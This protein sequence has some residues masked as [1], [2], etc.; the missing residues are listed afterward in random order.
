MQ[1]VA[2][3]QASVAASVG[4]YPGWNGQPQYKCGYSGSVWPDRTEIEPQK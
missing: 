1:A 2:T 4:R 3:F